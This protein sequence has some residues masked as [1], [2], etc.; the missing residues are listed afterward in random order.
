MYCTSVLYQNY[1]TVAE[2]YNVL[3]VLDLWFQS[4]KTILRKLNRSDEEG[5]ARKGSECDLM[6]IYFG[7]RWT[8]GGFEV[9]IRLQ[10]LSAS[11]PTLCYRRW[12]CAWCHKG[13]ILRRG[14]RCDLRQSAQSS[15]RQ[16]YTNLFGIKLC[17]FRRWEEAG[18]P[19]GKTQK[20]VKNLVFL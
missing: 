20:H 9:N 12:S 19:A 3:S 13:L 16:E 8:F 7:D 11:I 2:G 4:N 5:Q 17:V 6:G 10:C 15:F 14:T 18:W 1:A